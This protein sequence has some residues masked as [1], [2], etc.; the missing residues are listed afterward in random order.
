M[1]VTRLAASGTTVGLCPITEANPG[2]GI[3]RATEFLAAGGRFGIGT[4]SN[5]KISVAGELCTLEYV[6]RLT[7]RS[8]NLISTQPGAS[9]GRSIYDAAMT[10]G[11]AS[12][13]TGVGGLFVNA[14]ANIVSLASDSAEL[15]IRESGDTLID[16]FIF[17]GRAGSAIDKVWVRG[18]QVVSHGRHYQ[19]DKIAAAFQTTLRSVL[20]ST[21]TPAS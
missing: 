11:N 20:S 8:R 19:R 17:A 2:D 14:P 3:F 1:E 5:V 18:Q 9:T 15:I 6:Q 21:T 10:G 12:L 13:H 4:D 7:H 16:Q